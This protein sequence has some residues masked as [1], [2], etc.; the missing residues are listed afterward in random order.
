MDDSVDDD[1]A[2]SL[3]PLVARIVWGI[4]RS[5]LNLLFVVPSGYLG[6]LTSE[7]PVSR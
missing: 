1:Q 6:L 2:S 5:K 7:A 3:A 4:Q